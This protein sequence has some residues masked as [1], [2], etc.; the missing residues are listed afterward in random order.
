MGLDSQMLK[1]IIARANPQQAIKRYKTRGESGNEGVFRICHVLR[2]HGIVWEDAN[3]YLLAWFNRWEKVLADETGSQWDFAD[4]EVMAEEIWD[5]I[6][7]PGESRFQLAVSRAKKRLEAGEAIPNL[8]DYGGEPERMLALTC[9]ELSLLENPFYV[10]E[11]EAAEIMW[12]DREGGRRKGRTTL[13]VFQKR[14]IISL[15]K[16]GNQFNSTR[17]KYTGYP[18]ESVPDSQMK[19]ENTEEVR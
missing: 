14:R 4:I 13:K 19:S 2:L 12:L 10:G 3:P 17:F 9:Y 1:N 18:P 5:E 11:R 15:F 7:H 16:K 8:E 6:D